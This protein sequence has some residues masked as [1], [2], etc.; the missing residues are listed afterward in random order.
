V[1]IQ[2]LEHDHSLLVLID[3]ELDLATAPKLNDALTRAETEGMDIVVD[4]DRVSFLDS[5]GLHVLLRH[6]GT[7]TPARLRVT[8]GSAQVQRLFEVSGVA[9]LL[10]FVDD[11]AGRVPRRGR[12]GS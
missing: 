10:T 2:L 11:D 7:H 4:L 8:R 6:A 12:G 5:S 1:N 9:H 3:G